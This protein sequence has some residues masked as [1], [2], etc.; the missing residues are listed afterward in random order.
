MTE[1]EILSSLRTKKFGRT[2]HWYDTIDSTNNRARQLAID[3]A[4]EGTLVI[5][6]YQTS[7]KGRM[8][9]RWEAEPGT[10]LTFTLILT[11]QIPA[12]DTGI[13]PLIAG[14][15]VAQA[16]ESVTRKRPVCK[17]PNDILMDGKKVCGILAE[18]VIDG[19]A[20]RAIVVGIGVN[21]NQTNF[22]P[23]LGE[24]ATSLL[25]ATGERYARTQVL[26]AIL[27]QFESL[28]SYLERRKRDEF[29]KQYEAYTTMIGTAVTLTHSAGTAN[30]IVAGIDSEGGIMIR[31]ADGKTSTWYA[32]DVSLISGGLRR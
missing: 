25:L 24:T 6:N 22:P 21:V 28:I 20:V 12:A 29:L 30:G 19:T 15:A 17:W 4:E 9:R 32:G 31:G 27:G 3:G 14:L 8:G 10:N 1:Q 2:I 11:P 26:A 16:I 5:A 23:D 13:I 7:G 18:S